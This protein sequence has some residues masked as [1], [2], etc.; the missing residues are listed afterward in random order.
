MTYRTKAAGDNPE[1]LQEVV[2][3][4]LKRIGDEVK[5]AG[6]KAMTEAK[7]AGQLSA[8]TKESVDKLL[9]KQGELQARLQEAEQKLD[10]RGSGDQEGPQSLGSDFVG[11]DGYKDYIAAGNFRKG[12]THAVKAATVMTGG[13]APAGS[14]IAPD[15]QG[16]IV[17]PGLRRMTI[18]DL[19]TPG[20]T[21]S[22]L[23]QYVQ[24]TGFNDGATVTAE[25]IKK[26]QSDITLALK[27]AAVVKIAT[28]VKASM[29]ILMDAAMMQSYID[30]RLRHMLALK[31]E[32]ELL[33][34]AGGSGQI[35]GLV[36]QAT[37]YVAPITIANATDIDTLRLALLQAELAE[38]PSTGI[39][40]HPA[41]W[42]AIELTKDAGK[43]YLFANPQGSAQPSL[44]GRPVV[45]TQAM[46]GGEF[47]VGAFQL[48]AQIF[49]R[50][51]TTVTVATENED[52][53]LKNLIAI[54]VEERL[55]LAVYRPEAFITG[56]ITAVA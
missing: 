17:A 22:N 48:G 3:A 25:G 47:L 53:F 33:N 10:R 45:S 56:D 36:T 1:Q 5:S 2:T 12:F 43:N 23:I 11:A 6:E 41:N 40:L 28:Y 20:R 46:A 26:T 19:L 13:T 52:D 39:V 38:F 27:D 16:G 42:A 35:N 9:V 8:E 44:W 18:R 32:N 24:E 29:E 49:D 14:A 54:L 50:M 34:G 4:E 15:R 7:N 30:G 31:E 51:Q 21:S 55:T 37:A